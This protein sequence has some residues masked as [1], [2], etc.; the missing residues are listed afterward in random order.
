MTAEDC[1]Y[2]PLMLLQSTHCRPLFTHDRGH[3]CSLAFTCSETGLQTPLWC[4]IHRISCSKGLVY[5]YPKQGT[6]SLLSF[7]EFQ[8]LL[9]Q[10]LEHVPPLLLSRSDVVWSS[11]KF[12]VLNSNSQVHGFSFSLNL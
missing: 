7:L 9:H 5:E 12:T 4:L 3:H 2:P 6:E 11:V 1:C 10:E 8:F